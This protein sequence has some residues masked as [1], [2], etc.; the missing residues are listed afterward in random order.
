MEKIYSV[1]DPEKLLHV[2]CRRDDIDGK[3]KDFA[4]ENEILQVATILLNNGECVDAHKHLKNQRE[5]NGT[6]EVIMVIEGELE[7]NFYDT[8]D[9]LIKNVILYG[10]DCFVTYYGGHAVKSLKDKTKLYEVKNGP[11]NGKDKD[12]SPIK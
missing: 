10:G 4:S 2:I 8:N 3:R 6:Q 1:L 9:S 5:T 11:Y 7:V 12:K